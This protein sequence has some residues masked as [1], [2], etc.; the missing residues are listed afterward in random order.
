MSLLSLAQFA[1]WFLAG[2]ALGAV[3]LW[4]IGRTVAMIA[5]P[6]AKSVAAAFVVL[7]LA[8]AAGVFWGAATQGA[9]PL[10]LTL[11]GFLAARTVAVRAMRGADDGS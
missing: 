1:G 7:R 2:A 8:L 4:L 3:Y 10:L 11:L 6:A 5:P 9:A